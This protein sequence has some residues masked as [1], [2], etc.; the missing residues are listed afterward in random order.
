MISNCFF[1]YMTNVSSNA[2]GLQTINSSHRL[3]IAIQI[4]I[5]ERANGSKINWQDVATYL[6]VK[7]VNN[8][9]NYELKIR[10]SE[11]VFNILLP[12]HEVVVCDD[13]LMTFK[14]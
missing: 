9:V 1:I 10:M 11:P 13:D 14:H 12:A 6:N 4:T 2:T 7:R 3:L 8:V 5:R